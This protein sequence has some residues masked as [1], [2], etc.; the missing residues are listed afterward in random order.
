MYLCGSEQ[1][2]SNLGECELSDDFSKFYGSAVYL[3]KGGSVASLD[4]RRP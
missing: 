4:E 1:N 2:D 3:C